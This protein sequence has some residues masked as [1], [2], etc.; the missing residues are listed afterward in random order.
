VRVSL[1]GDEL[2]AA[3]LAGLK[4]ADRW[5]AVGLLRAIAQLGP[6][7]PL[8][9]ERSDRWPAW[10][11]RLAL[12]APAAKV[13]ASMKLLLRSLV[14]FLEH[15][16]HDIRRSA[17]LGLA[18]FGPAAGDA[19]AVL[20]AARLPPPLRHDVLR[21]LG[22]PSVLDPDGFPWD[23]CTVRP[24]L[25]L[26]AIARGCESLWARADGGPLDYPRA[27]SAVPKWAFLEYLVERRGLLLHGSRTAG[28]DV[29]RPISRSGGGTRISD[30]PGVF[31]VDHALM[32]MYFGIV[33]RSRVPSLSNTLVDLAHPDGAPVHGFR[34]GT[35][36]VALAGRPFVDATVYILPPDTFSKLGEWT[37]LVPVRPLA[38]LSITPQDLPLL[39]YLWGTDL[40]P[41]ASQ[42]TDE[43]PGLQDVAFWATKRSAL[44]AQA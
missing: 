41:L 44:S 38:S 42:F 11:S 39:E 12:R 18:F 10:E 8:L 29:L 40:G 35:D 13:E 1:S 43:Y 23:L 33:D 37:S 22:V 20:R 30:Q 17:A 21:R 25:D 15:P 4:R 16:D 2:L 19:A 14:E 5:L 7:Y 27:R 24:P 32:A 6:H 9:P 36:F 31:A 28:I 3:L 26:D 34:L